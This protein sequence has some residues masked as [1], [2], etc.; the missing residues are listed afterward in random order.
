MN[1]LY[2][3]LINVEKKINSGVNK[4]INGQI[5]AMERQGLN[6]YRIALKNS[7]L[8]VFNNGKEILFLAKN[9]NLLRKE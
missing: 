1:C 7:G 4:K 3:S 9:M 8:Y 6:M 5:K 2:L